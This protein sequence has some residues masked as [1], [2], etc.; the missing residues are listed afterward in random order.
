ML[1]TCPYRSVPTRSHLHSSPTASARK[2]PRSLELVSTLN[3][4]T[5]N[6]PIKVLSQFWLGLHN[7]R[8][9]AI[10]GQSDFILILAAAQTTNILAGAKKQNRERLTHSSTVVGD[11]FLLQICEF[12]RRSPFRMLDSERICKK[13]KYIVGIHSFPSSSSFYS[14]PYYDHLHA[15][16]Y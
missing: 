1:A 7:D 15:W 4:G 8:S 3:G 5:G 10:N 13:T 16:R 6:L 2:I 14:N 12:E 9:K 11:I